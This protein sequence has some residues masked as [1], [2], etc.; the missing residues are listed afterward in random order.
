G[1]ACGAE[2]HAWES[3]AESY[4]DPNFDL[5]ELAEL[6]EPQALGQRLLQS[7]DRFAMLTPKAHLRAWL[8]FAGDEETHAQ[9]LAGARKLAHR[10]ADAVEMLRHDE[11]EAATVLAYLPLLDLDA[12]PPLCTSSRN[13]LHERLAR[14]YRPKPDDPPSYNEL[15]S[16][17]GGDW[18]LT[19]LEWLAVRGCDV[20]GELNEAVKLVE[21]YQDSPARTAMLASLKQAQQKR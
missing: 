20:D 3:M 14:V 21:I 7:P 1:C 6:R 4:R 10:T 17:L 15:L 9:A 16:R 5:Y 19:A 13:T 18:P 12:T 11:F 8:K 2:S